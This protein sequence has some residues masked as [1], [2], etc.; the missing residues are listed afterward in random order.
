MTGALVAFVEA[1]CE[2]GPRHRR[3]RRC[4]RRAGSSGDL[5]R[6]R[7]ARGADS[8][9]SA[10]SIPGDF[11]PGQ[12]RGALGFVVDGPWRLLTL[13]GP[14]LALLLLVIRA[15]KREP[16]K[17]WVPALRTRPADLIANPRQVVKSD[18]RQCRRPEP[19][20]YLQGASAAV[21]EGAIASARRTALEPPP[22]ESAR[23]TALFCPPSESA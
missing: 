19:R 17:D 2:A 20:G 7:A 8:T 22:S 11:G 18:R 23:R 4:H 21:F 14:V 16:G 12:E 10:P 9:R 5:A 13:R 1:D 6:R 3:R 15:K